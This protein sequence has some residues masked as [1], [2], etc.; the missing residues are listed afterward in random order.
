MLYNDVRP[1]RFAAVVGQESEVKVIKTVLERNW[2]PA[3]FLITGPFGC[4]KTSLARLIARALLCDNRQGAEPCGEC[5]SCKSMDTDSHPAYLEIDAASHGL[6]GDIRTLKDEALYKVVGGKTRIIVFDEA[7]MISTPGQNAMLQI[8]EE[9]RAGLLYIFATTEAE[10]MLPTVR[11]RCVELDL[12]I[13]STAQVYQQLK[14]VSAMKS[15]VAEDRALRVMATYS[16][17]HLRDAL[18]LLEQM[19]RTS[20]GQVTEELVRVHLRL[21]KMA[22]LYQ[23]LVEEHQAEAA[24][25]LEVLLCS[26]SV[27]ELAENL[28]QALVDAY[29]IQLDIGEYAEIDKA[30]LEKITMSQGKESLLHRAEQLLSLH[31]DFASINY[32][33]AAVMR[34]FYPENGNGHA[35]RVGTRTLVPGTGTIPQSFRKPSK[36]LPTEGV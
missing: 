4:G 7:H 34:I 17:G 15:I 25:K 22:E 6:I 20:A 33:L 32:G 11:S 1:K 36:P 12:K 2:R 9:G 18:V 31:T 14:T 21:D 16:R 23:F 24:K 29:K 8:L 28:A 30:M 19:A 35:S 27:G 5:G 10:K 13:L 26:Y 3:A